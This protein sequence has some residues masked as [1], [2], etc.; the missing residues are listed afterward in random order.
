M[1]LTITSSPASTKTTKRVISNHKLAVL[2]AMHRSRTYPSLKTIQIQTRRARNQR[3]Q[4][5]RQWHHLA[6]WA[7]LPLICKREY[8]ILSIKYEYKN[9]TF[10]THL[11]SLVAHLNEPNLFE[12]SVGIVMGQVQHRSKMSFVSLYQAQPEVKTLHGIR[13]TLLHQI[14]RKKK[15]A[16]FRNQRLIAN[17]FW[18]FAAHL[19]LSLPAKYPPS[20]SKMPQNQVENAQ[21]NRKGERR[22]RRRK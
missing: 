3:C 21:R 19:Q 1:L 18:S 13:V 22:A 4:I 6:D 9:V 10:P 20:T 8:L 14:A 5:H 17:P 16:S 2:R 11:Q 7:W 15:K 12:I